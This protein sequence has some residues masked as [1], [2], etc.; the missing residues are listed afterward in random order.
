[1]GRGKRSPGSSD[2]RWGKRNYAISDRGCGQNQHVSIVQ[3]TALYYYELDNLCYNIDV[4]H[5]R[6][7]INKTRTIQSTF[8]HV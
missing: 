3:K 8:L 2:G 1:M 5:H 7:Q 6:S 4:M